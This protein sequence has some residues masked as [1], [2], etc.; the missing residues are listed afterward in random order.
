M[1]GRSGSPTAS[2]ASFLS[3]P[4]PKDA[5]NRLGNS[6]TSSEIHS[7]KNQAV[8]SHYYAIP[9]NTALRFGDSGLNSASTEDQLMTPP[10]AASPSTATST[11]FILSPSP[12]GFGGPSAGPTSARGSTS[13][14]KTT[15]S[16]FFGL[17]TSK[18]SSSKLSCSSSFPPGQPGQQQWSPYPPFRFSV[19]F[20]DIASLKEKSRLHSQTFWYAGSLFNVY[21][22]IL[23]K[24]S[25]GTGDQI[26][27]KMGI[28]L[29]RQSSVEELPRASAPSLISE[30]VE[31]ERVKPRS[32]SGSLD[33]GMTKVMSGTQKKPRAHFR[34][35]SLPNIHT[36]TG[37]TPPSPSHFSPSIH[38]AS[39][40]RPTTPNSALGGGADTPSLP[41]SSS[42]PNS[43]FPS[44]VSN[45]LPATAPVS[46]PSQP[47]RDPRGKVSAYFAISCASATG[48]SQTRFTSSPD[49]FGISK[50]EF[51]ICLLAR[52]LTCFSSG[53]GWPSSS[54]RT[55][56]Y[57]DQGSGTKETGKEVSFRATVV[58]GLV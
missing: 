58:L 27:T 5:G 23:R 33:E 34:G 42:H 26:Q 8:Q 50:S 21:T 57:V 39:R 45:T 13:M 22:Q 29:Q 3:H 28:Y 56:E 20:F 6:Q 51:L 7:A 38:P 1:A 16:N 24:K 19:E 9:G 54:L 31:R 35:P 10:G 40:S 17:T 44:T 36:V 15:E 46:A 37:S 11:P 18:Q 55:E 30:R 2:P 25:G 41:S 47:Y 49:E 32:E 48:T 12:S 52:L 43:Y 14:L 4:H 53:W